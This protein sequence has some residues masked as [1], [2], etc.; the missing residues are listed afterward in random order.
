MNIEKSF[1]LQ[2]VYCGSRKN[3][4]DATRMLEFT[5]VITKITE[6]SEKCE[7]ESVRQRIGYPRTCKFLFC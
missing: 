7:R 4:C 1:Y 2:T 5:I 3:V 6:E